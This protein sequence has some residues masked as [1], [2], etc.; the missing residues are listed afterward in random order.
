MSVVLNGSSQY[1]GNGTG[2]VSA[3]GFTVS[4]AIKPDIF[5]AAQQGWSFGDK[6]TGFNAVSLFHAGN[7]GGD[8]VRASVA[9][10]AGG[11][12]RVASTTSGA[13]STQWYRMTATFNSTTLMAVFLDGANKGSVGYVS[14]DPFANSMPNHYV[15]RLASSLAD[16][17]F[18]GKLAG[19]CIW[20]TVLS[21]GTIANLTAAANPADVQPDDIV[22]LW[23]LLSDASATTGSN[24]TAFNSPTFD[25]A[26]HPYTLFNPAWAI[27]ANRV[28]GAG[29]AS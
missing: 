2:P 1:L 14:T 28:I 4:I 7:I 23:H 27:N 15:G 21:D 11:A 5:T 16:Q 19:L 25:A 24:F 9:D 17:Y 8:P 3:L 6:S 20:D 13:T 10:T 12:F 22:G 18:D 26:D 29:I